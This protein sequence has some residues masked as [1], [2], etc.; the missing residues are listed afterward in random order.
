MKIIYEAS[1]GS[2]SF[3]MT[4]ADIIEVWGFDNER[5]E[6]FIYLK[7]GSVKTEKDFHYEVMS[8]CSKNVV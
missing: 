4:D 6:S 5:P 1:V 7:E 8:W 3:Q 2:Y